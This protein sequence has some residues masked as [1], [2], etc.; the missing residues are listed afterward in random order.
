[1]EYVLFDA[2]DIQLYAREPGIIREVGYRTRADDARARLAVAGFTGAL[3]QAVADAL[4]PAAKAYARSSAARC[5][6]EGLAAVE[7][8]ES[9]SFDASSRTYAGMWLDLTALATDLR[10]PLASA[11]LRATALAAQLAGLPPESPVALDTS[12]LTAGRRPGERTFKRIALSDSESLLQAVVG[13][14]PRRAERPAP[15]SGER[16]EPLRCSAP[17]S[18]ER[19]EPGPSR[20][21]ALG[22]L[23]DRARRRPASQQRLTALQAALTSREP[24]AR[25]PLAETALWNLEARL[26]RGDTVG[27]LDQIDAIERRRGRV[28]ATAYLRARVALMTG[29][30]PP[31]EIAERVSAL[32]TS[33][34]SF[35]E[36][37]LLAAQAWWAAGDVRRARAFADD[38]LGDAGTDDVLRTHALELLQAAGR[39][40]SAHRRVAP[41][42]PIEP[43]PIASGGPGDSRTSE[44]MQPSIPRPPVA[45]SV[46]ELAL[47]VS[48]LPAPATSTSAASQPSYRIEACGERGWATLPPGTVAVELVETLS[49]PD[50]GRS[51]QGPAAHAD[52]GRSPQGP[53]AHA[54]VGRSPQGPAAHTEGTS[55]SE[56][57]APRSGPA[58]RIA[59]TLLARELGMELRLG[60]GVTLRNDLDG[61]EQAQRYLREALVDRR[62]QTAQEHRALLRHGAFLSELLAR[63]LGARW[64]DVKSVDA[65]EWAMLIA[66]P[67]RPDEAARVWPFARAL[68]FIAMGHTER[69]LVSYYLEL[70]ALARGSE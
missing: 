14:G 15:L 41:A 3:A 24:P 46:P 56:C 9:P 6:V 1:V 11:L 45:P 44:V 19:A 35:H 40:S 60:H 23:Q 65:C 34:A 10:L 16:A 7:L 29:S 17:L 58:A 30:E 22:W 49:L 63:R 55:P 51:P 20:A 38:L 18:G 62:V 47:P 2:G 59:C 48:A 33:M 32:S 25:G 61:L 66:L 28:P 21:D 50:V 64:V 39:S 13:L 27:V 8:L 69:D 57:D 42:T 68:R 36:L 53:A 52:V 54:D 67:R 43:D 31:G 12:E 26:A 70:Q 4:R 37:Q 5:L